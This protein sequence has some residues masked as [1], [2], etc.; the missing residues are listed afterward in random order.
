[1]ANEGGFKYLAARY[2]E[3]WVEIEGGD[4]QLSGVAIDGV[5]PQQEQG[6]Y[7]HGFG[8]ASNVIDKDI[9]I[10]AKVVK[11]SPSDRASLKA[12]FYQVL[13]PA[14]V[15]PLHAVPVAVAVAAPAAVPARLRAKELLAT[16]SFG[17][18][19]EVPLV[20]IV[21]IA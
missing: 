5:P 13:P 14:V 15:S 3:L 12:R 17:A 19:V 11:T 9:I 6:G 21:R 20:L 16:G 8:L 4:G 18:S 1:M 7:R 10:T 2:L